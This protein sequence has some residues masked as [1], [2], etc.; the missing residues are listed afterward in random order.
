[1]LDRNKPTPLYVQL[2]EEIR[3]SIQDGNWEIG[4]AIPSENELGKCYGISRMTVRQVLTKLVNEGLLYRVQGKGTFIAEPKIKTSSLAYRGIREQLEELGYE[5]GTKLLR[6]E[7]QQPSSDIQLSLELSEEDS[8]YYI[9]RLRYANGKPLSIHRSYLP[10]KVCSELSDQ[11]METE[12][13]C[14]ILKDTYGLVPKRFL[15]TLESVIAHPDEKELLEL[16]PK[17]TIL[18]LEDLIYS[19]DGIPYE[20]SKVLFRGD[21]IKLHFEYEN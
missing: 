9:E 5:T 16:P 6:F 1:M 20:F 14:V 11:L 10:C 2:E 15:E 7:K 17:F 13:L 4:H 18:K 3:T 8:V 19:E 12:Q 21:R